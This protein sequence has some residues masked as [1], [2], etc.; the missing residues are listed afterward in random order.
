MEEKKPG[1]REV[2]KILGMAALIV[3]LFLG[4]KLIFWGLGMAIPQTNIQP[5]AV[6]Q[7]TVQDSTPEARPAPSFCVH[8][9]EGLPES[10]L[11]GQFCPYC[12]KRV[13]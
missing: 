5:P 3:A 1:R 10:F 4:I 13:E 2:W 9:G 8:C 11:W 6:S 7:S 12:G